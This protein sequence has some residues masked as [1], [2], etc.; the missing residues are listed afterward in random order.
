ML[1]KGVQ[2]NTIPRSIAMV[3]KMLG[4]VRDRKNIKSSN[5]VV[6]KGRANIILNIR[7]IKIRECPL[8]DTKMS[9]MNMSLSEVSKNISIPPP[10][11]P[12]PMPTKW[13][14]PRTEIKMH[15]PLKTEPI[16]QIKLSLPSRGFDISL[17]QAVRLRHVEPVERGTRKNTLEMILGARMAVMVSNIETEIEDG[18][19][20]WEN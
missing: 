6:Y 15:R 11:P 18:N 5:R 16:S 13:I 2:V 3:N 20:E 10:P 17:I 7:P 1:D 9:G 19:M 12:P 8:Y 14:S 4:C